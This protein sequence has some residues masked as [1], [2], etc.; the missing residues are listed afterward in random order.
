MVLGRKPKHQKMVKFHIRIPEE[1]MERLKH[2]AGH[3]N[4]SALARMILERGIGL[5]EKKVQN[6]RNEGLDN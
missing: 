4:V 3:G 6:G 5:E 1:T 2:I